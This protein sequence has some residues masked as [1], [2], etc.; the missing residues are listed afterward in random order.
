MSNPVTSIINPT[1]TISETLLYTV[2]ARNQLGLSYHPLEEGN[3]ITEYTDKG[4]PQGNASIRGGLAAVTYHGLV[5]V[6]GFIL[7]DTSSEKKSKDSG[8][9]TCG[10]TCKCVVVES[11]KSSDGS[12]H[13]TYIISQLSPVEN[14]VAAEG[15]METTHVGLAAISHGIDR[16]WIYFLKSKNEGED[17]KLVESTLVGERDPTFKT[18]EFSA[19]PSSKLAAVYVH[20]RDERVVFFQHSSQEGRCIQ[21]L[22]IGNSP[23]I[24]SD[25]MTIMNTTSAANG[26]PLAATYVKA[27]DT[28]AIYLYY[29]NDNLNLTRAVYDFEQKAW[30]TPAVV[31][32]FP[33]ALL[34]SQLTVSADKAH[35][36]VFYIENDNPRQGYINHCDAL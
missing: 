13:D 1:S 3:N 19:V 35:N 16:A 23:S 11:G 15:T 5:K 12:A 10:A 4:V 14:P 8:A 28:S 18:F 17:P 34:T 21:W 25:A 29:V 20:G 24:I 31:P 32:K 30:S 2:T 9:C 6:Y 33:R 22:R 7:K 27:G 36:H 26:T